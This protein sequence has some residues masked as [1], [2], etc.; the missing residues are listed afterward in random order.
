GRSVPVVFE[1]CQISEVVEEVLSTL[2]LVAN[3][4]QIT[5]RCEGMADAP[6]LLAD[7]NRLY[8]ALYNLIDNAIPEVPPGGAITIRA[9]A[10][11]SDMLLLEI[12]DS[13]GGMAP[14]VRD[15]LFSERVR[16]RKRGGTG[17][18]T[19]IVQDVVTAHGGRI[20][21]TSEP[22]RGTTFLL[23]LPLNP[24]PRTVPP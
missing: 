21:V 23:R 8:T 6:A 24:S 18:G 22:G 3:E 12:E 9:R 13:G 5:I 4:R 14:E 2:R 10:D 15:S 7:R 19:K 1:P 20:S 17:L 11:E 16:S